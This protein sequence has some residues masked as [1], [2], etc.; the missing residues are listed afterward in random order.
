MKIWLKGY[1]H[2]GADVGFFP[3]RYLWDTS[4]PLCFYECSLSTTTGHPRTLT[5]YTPTLMLFDKV[6]VCRYEMDIR[7]VTE[8]PTYDALDSL[9]RLVDTN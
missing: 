7:V 5:K 6:W 1:Y 8:V 3:D 4:E 9:S 2:I